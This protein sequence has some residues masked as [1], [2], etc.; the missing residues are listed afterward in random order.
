MTLIHGNDVREALGL[1]EEAYID[2]AILIGTDF[3]QR[4]K[5]V[6]PSRAYKF[7]KEYGTIE[8]IIESQT[9]HQ[10]SIARAEYLAQVNSARAIFSSLPH[11]PNRLKLAVMSTKAGVADQ[12]KV[13]VVMERCGLGRALMVDA[14]WDYGTALAGNYFSDNPSMIVS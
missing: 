12:A 14:C 4:I 5:N 8:N 7:I 3:S 1:S 11:I 10:P 9:K 2:F 6:G 13:E